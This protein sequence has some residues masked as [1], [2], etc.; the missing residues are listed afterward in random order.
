M[1]MAP[2]WIKDQAYKTSISRD[3]FGERGKW[4][5]FEYV[6][7]D[8]VITKRTVAMWE[9]RGAYIVGYDRTRKEERTFRQDR[10]S[11]WVSG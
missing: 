11:D 6:G 4:A 10:I 5:S 1:R 3:G 7:A 8:G 2:R 9:K